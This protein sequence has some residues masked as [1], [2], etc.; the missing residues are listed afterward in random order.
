MSRLSNRRFFFAVAC[1]AIL[2]AKVVHLSTYAFVLPPR[3][4]VCWGLSFFAQD[5]VLL[6]LV[7][8]LIDPHMFAWYRPLQLFARMLA[9]AA[10]FAIAA[11]AVLELS[12][13]MATGSEVD[14]D[15]VRFTGDVGSWS[16]LLAGF[17]ALPVSV[18]GCGFVAWAAQDHLYYTSTIAL[19]ILK[20]PFVFLLDRLTSHFPTLRHIRYAHLPKCDLENEGKAHAYKEDAAA[21]GYSDSEI[22]VADANETISARK[23]AMWPHMVIGAVMLTLFLLSTTRPEQS[24][25]T[26]MSWTLPFLPFVNVTHTKPSTTIAWTWNNITT[27]D[28][29]MPLSWLPKKKALHGFE[30]WWIK[31]ATHYCAAADPMRISN[32]DEHLLPEL[33]YKLNGTMIRHVMLLVLDST[34]KDAFPVRKNGPLWKTLAGSFGDRGLPATVHNKLAFLTPTADYLT[35]GKDKGFRHGKRIRRG[36]ISVDN[37]FTSS[38][39]PLKSLGSALCGVS[40]LVGDYDAELY[41]RMYQPCLPHILNAFNEVGNHGKPAWNGMTSFKWKSSLVQSATAQREG[42]GAI[43]RRWGFD[44]RIV[45]DGET[46]RGEDFA[47]GTFKIDIED[48]I[49]NAFSSAQ[50]KQERLFLTHLTGLSQEVFMPVDDENYVALNGDTAQENISRYTNAI[51]YSDRW[52]AR[53]LEILEEQGVAEETLVVVAGNHGLSI[54]EDGAIIPYQSTNVANLHVPLVFSHPKL[55]PINLQQPAVSIQILPTILDLLLATYSIRGPARVA[56][57]DL[58]QN[59]EGQSLLRPLLAS[60]PQTGQANW[61]FSVVGADRPAVSVRD[62]RQPAWQLVVPGSDD[63][64]DWRFANTKADPSEETPLATTSLAELVWAVRKS[65]GGTAASWVDEAA[66]MASWWVKDGRKRWLY[67]PRTT[68][69]S[70]TTTTKTTG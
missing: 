65:H 61:Q 67:H 20:W 29:P 17:M 28:K 16:T 54:V 62:A 57:H 55:P 8:L 40:P 44:D 42:Q 47:N 59:Y 31:N 4:M 51:G 43:I 50:E 70:I 48:H 66:L 63:D 23:P 24:T 11:L 13:F 45:V 41:S 38:T 26:L 25:L 35:G 7:R 60:S 53:V 27:L 33:S 18:L 34:R 52:L 12:T 22:E 37:A 21:D 1:V 30:D 64:A 49:K 5:L 36:G 2:S 39:Y 6:I 10:V 46:P 15:H 14:W 69:T 32:L 56:A 58:M 68:T 3:E 19:N 9:A